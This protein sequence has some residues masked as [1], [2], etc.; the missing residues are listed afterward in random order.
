MTQTRQQ[1]VICNGPDTVE[2]TPQQI[3]VFCKPIE[4]SSYVLGWDGPDLQ[5]AVQII[6][7]LQEDIAERIEHDRKNFEVLRACSL[8]ARE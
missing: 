3:D 4:D 5:K 6:R 1:P 7:Q 2:F 8:S